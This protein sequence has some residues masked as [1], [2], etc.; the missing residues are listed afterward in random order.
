MKCQ[1]PKFPPWWRYKTGYVQNSRCLSWPI[2]L[3][4]VPFKDLFR[5]M[6]RILLIHTG[7]TMGMSHDEDDGVASDQFVDEILSH[8]PGIKDIAEIDV[9]SVFK[10]D[11]SNFSIHHWTE[12]GTII[13]DHMD[14]YDGFVII[15]GTDTMSYSACALSYMLT[16]LPKPVVLTGS[17]RP[18]SAIRTDAK[19]NLINAV[20]L[21]T[22]DIPEVGVFFDYKLFRGNRTKKTSIDDF[23]AFESPNYPVL[24]DVGLHIEI[25]ERHRTPQGVFK[26]E[27]GFDPRVACIRLFPGLDPRHLQPLIS[28]P[29]QLI[30]IEAFGSGNVPTEWLSFI[31]FIR[32]VTAAGK[33][34]AIASQSA[35]GSVDLALYDGGRQAVEAGAISCGDMTVEAAIIKAMY[36]LGSSGGSTAFV[37]SR[38]GTSIAGEITEA[39]S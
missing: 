15:H 20:E 6:K 39:P 29:L 38:F 1:P 16:N 9:R 11:S 7:G 17:Q 26:L 21:A 35:R 34:A 30:I 14:R 24:A 25:P 13:A 28:S 37:R 31:P 4:W 10:I 18:L 12:L 22:H 36:L 8:V 27:G 23:D 3:N 33:L 32:D 2:R 19:N 5:M